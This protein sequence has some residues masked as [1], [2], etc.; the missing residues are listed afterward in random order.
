MDIRDP[1]HGSIT[2]N[3]AEGAVVDSAAFQRLRNIK[4]LGFGE[5]SFPG[6]THSRYLHSLGAFHLSG[7]AFD[8][9]F[10]NF[11]FENKKNAK[12]FRQ[13]LRIATLLHDVGHG[14][15]SHSSEEVMPPLKDLNIK[16]YDNLI[17]PKLKRT[18]AN[19]E[20]YAIKL[21]TDSPLTKIIQKNFSDITPLHIACLIDPKIKAPDDFFEESGFSL[22]PIL[23]QIVS[24]EL[25]VDRMDYLNRD[26]YFCGTSYGK[27]DLDWLISNLTY[28]QHKDQMNLAISRRAMYTFDDFLISRHHMYL[29]IYFHH[30]SI[31]YDEMLHRYLKSDDCGYKIPADI[32]E[33]LNYTDYHFYEHIAR[34][35]NPWARRITEKKPFVRIFELHET[36]KTTTAEKFKKKLEGEGIELIHASSRARLSKYHQ[37]LSNENIDRRIYVVDPQGYHKPYAIEESTEIFKRYE[38]ARIIERIYV[39]PDQKLQSENLLK[40]F[41]RN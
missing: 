37:T 24:S 4:Q 7:I 13:A 23:S 9:I 32:E 14:P 33:Y 31:V 11:P 39:R 25:D 20:D 6:A 15:L 21:I 26:S 3:S 34:S 2:L 16:A 28:H 38:Q 22:R 19:H 40:E 18:Q 30:K 27:I 8:K 10:S 41:M 12:R 5:L 35:S 17:G 29:M 1:L 36:E